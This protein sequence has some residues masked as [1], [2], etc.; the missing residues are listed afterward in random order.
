MAT[1]VISVMA[2]SDWTLKHA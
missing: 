2:T 1:E